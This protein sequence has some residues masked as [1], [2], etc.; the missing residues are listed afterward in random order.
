MKALVVSDVHRNTQ[1][2]LTVL[3]KLQGSGQTLDLSFFLGDG[4]ELAVPLL[5]RRTPLCHAVSGN[6]DDYGGEDTMIV[7]VEGM[8][9]LLAHGHRQQVKFGYQRLVYTALEQEAQICLFGHT[10]LPALFYEQGILFMNPG[11]IGHPRL[12]EQPSFG[13]IEWIGQSPQSPRGA[14]PTL[15]ELDGETIRVLQPHN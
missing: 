10:H 12:G 13:M 4:Y 7:K 11:S 8:R 9:V 1:P 14:H 3:N 2:L 6:C 15:A 5:S